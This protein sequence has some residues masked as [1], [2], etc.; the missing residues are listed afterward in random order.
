M[1]RHQR[2]EDDLQKAYKA[3]GRIPTIRELA[4][5]MKWKKSDTLRVIR[6][7][8]EKGIFLIRKEAK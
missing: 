4:A 1:M 6:R 8:Q 5:Q 7:L 3:F 2:E